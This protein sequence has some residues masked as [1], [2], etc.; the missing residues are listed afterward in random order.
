M[1]FLAI[2]LPFRNTR[3]RARNPPVVE[4]MLRSSGTGAEQRC[5][6][7]KLEPN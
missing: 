1:T 7:V 5:S 6:G 2:W 4:E 3:W